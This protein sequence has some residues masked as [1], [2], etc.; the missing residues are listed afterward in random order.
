MTRYNTVPK[1]GYEHTAYRLVAD[2]TIFLIDCPS[3]FDRSLPQIDTIIFTHHHFLGASNLR[4]VLS[5]PGRH[6]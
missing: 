2:G 3:T 6:P 1:L 5:G 4:E